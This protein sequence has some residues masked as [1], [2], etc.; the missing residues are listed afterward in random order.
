MVQ[1]TYSVLCLKLHHDAWVYQRSHHKVQ[2]SCTLGCPLKTRVHQ[3]TLGYNEASMAIN[4]SI[5]CL[6][7]RIWELRLNLYKA[8][9]VKLPSYSLVYVNRSCINYKQLMHSD[10]SSENLLS[11]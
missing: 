5:R 10:L 7:T 11:Q 6:E 8:L 2:C 4:D 9:N 3:C 1:R